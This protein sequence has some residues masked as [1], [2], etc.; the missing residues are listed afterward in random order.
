MEP[1]ARIRE[2]FIDTNHLDI[3]L[4][5]FTATSNRLRTSST[6]TFNLPTA[7]PDTVWVD[8]YSEI[9]V[10]TFTTGAET[11]AAVRVNVTNGVGYSMHA[12]K[13][14]GDIE[15]LEIRSGWSVWSIAVVVASA[16][17]PPFRLRTE[18]IGEMAYCF[19]DG[20]LEGS[21]YLPSVLGAAFLSSGTPALT[22]YNNTAVANGEIETWEAGPLPAGYVPGSW[23][24][25]GIG[26]GGRV[27]NRARLR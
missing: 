22:M 1:N 24:S 26:S 25:P 27:P 21:L 12:I 7:L 3:A 8:Q 20:G 14:S 9:L 4:G 11:G 10:P 17:T 6:A 19:V 15:F 13:D 2:E 5:G 16:P 18:I 23:A